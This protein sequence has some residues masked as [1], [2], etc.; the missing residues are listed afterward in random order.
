MPPSHPT[1]S[2]GPETTRAWQR[3]AAGLIVVAWLAGTVAAGWVVPSVLLA[4]YDGES[5]P[6]LNEAIANHRAL[7][8]E[9]GLPTRDRAWYEAAAQRYGYRVIL[10]GSLGAVEPEGTPA[11][12]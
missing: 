9:R 8:D 4:A 10:Y 7:A 5:L 6:A 12:G 1:E 11:S 2:A 3:W